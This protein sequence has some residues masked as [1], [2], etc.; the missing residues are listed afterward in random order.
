MSV[1]YFCSQ[2]G[3]PYRLGDRYCIKCGAELASISK[4]TSIQ[5]DASRA[6]TKATTAARES[7]AETAKN[8]ETRPVTPPHL[9]S[10]KSAVATLLLCL[11]LGTLGIHRFYVGKIGT[12][13]L[14]L[15]TGGG[16]GI[17]TLIDLIVIACNEFKDK[18][19]R[20]V[21]FVRTD[22]SPFMKVIIAIAVVIGAF[23]LFILLMIALAFYATS[24]ITDT[25]RNQLSALRSGDYVKAYTFTSKEF[26]N[27][28]SLEQ[29]KQ[30]V[31]MNPSLKNNQDSSFYSREIK[32]NEGMIK[33]TLKAS[34]GTVTPVY[35]RLI[36]EDDNWKIMYIRIKPA[37]ITQETQ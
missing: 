9:V 34:D 13:I 18:E 2:C 4:D 21:E 27:A 17:W 14:M 23:I 29:F 3:T 10:P 33:G 8:A 11:F 15:L 26:Q 6:E 12:G 37:G 32:N 30:F 7:T 22:T 16:F 1:S 28:T 19:G 31:D 35:Y 5:T 24:G 20:Y 36:K 25:V